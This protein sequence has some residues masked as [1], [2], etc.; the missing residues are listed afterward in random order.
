MRP[1]S[2]LRRGFRTRHYCF[3]ASLVCC[4]GLLSL[5]ANAQYTENDL[6]S[7]AKDPNL[8]DGWGLVALP[9][10]PFWVSNQNTSTSTLYMANG[11]IVPLVVQ[12]PCVSSGTPT[13]PCP[14]PGLFPIAPPFGPTGIV[15]NT[16][17][18][19]GAFH[20][21]DGE[22]SEPA[23]FIFATLDGLIVGWNPNVKAQQAVVAARSEQA[24]YTGLAIWGRTD[25]PHL[26]AANA[27]GGID[28]FDA[29]FTWVNTFAADREPGPFTPYGI[30]AIGN[31]LYVAYASPAVAGGIVDVCN[32]ETSA[33]APKCRRLVGNFNAPFWL[34]GPWGLALSPDNFGPLSNKLLVGNVDSGWISAFNPESGHFEGLLRLSDGHPFTVVGL[35]GLQ[36]GNGA[37]ANGPTNHLFFA[38]G[39]PAP[40]KPI[41][42]LGLF[43]VITPPTEQTTK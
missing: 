16:F 38:A 25:D 21:H 17:A 20:V 22:K 10:S 41:F 35:W 37:P 1:Y 42:S 28:V 27:A 15:G 24:V 26:Y 29:S 43:G 34:S 36:F 30:Q 6:V 19:I 40:D 7:T 32:L 39:P 13:V 31:K 2:S 14:V 4:L 12:I 18:S 33:T 23:F 11:S 9:G 3:I 8:V 5:E